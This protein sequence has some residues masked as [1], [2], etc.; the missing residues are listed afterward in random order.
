[1]KEFT[2]D[3][4]FETEWTAY[5]IE[6]VMAPDPEGGRDVPGLGFVVNDICYR[7]ATFAPM[8]N[9]RDTDGVVKVRARSEA[10]PSWLAKTRYI[11]I[12][13]DLLKWLKMDKWILVDYVLVKTDE[14]WRAFCIRQG[15]P[16]PVWCEENAANWRP[17]G[18]SNTEL[19]DIEKFRKEIE[20]H[21]DQIKEAAWPTKEMITDTYKTYPRFT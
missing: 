5:H 14:P 4:T 1:M 7:G 6:Y 12:K 2:N 11:M 17:K 20:V 16:V 18:Y 10:F 19:T 3:V 15:R 8:Y 21:E 9:F 13:Q